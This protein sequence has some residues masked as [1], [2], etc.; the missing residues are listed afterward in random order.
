MPAITLNADKTRELSTFV[1]KHGL[2]KFFVAKDQ[3]A[4]IGAAAG[5][6]E[7]GT[8]E[9]KIF[10]FRGCDT[11]KNDDFYENARYKFGGDDFGEHMSVDF[12]HKCAD[13]PKLKSFK[14]V[15]TPT[16]VKC[17]AKVYK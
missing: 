6:H 10:Y 2:D 15:V 1:R 5:S 16:A 13:H 17:E 3:G 9:N 4:Y 11:K 12:L 8:F 7:D 14:V